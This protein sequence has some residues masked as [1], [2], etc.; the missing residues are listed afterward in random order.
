MTT[1][2]G[3]LFND[4]Q[5]KPL[6]TVGQQQ[7]GAY[8]LFFETGT[9]TPANVYADGALTTPLSQTPGAAQPSCT[10]DS[11]GR[12]NPIYMA[13]A[14]SPYRV[15]LFT[16]GGVKL[17]DTD[18]YVVP[19]SGSVGL[20]LYP[21]T[22][23]ETAASVTIVSYN[24][25]P[26]DVR[27]YGAKCDGATDDTTALT[28][29][30]AQAV[31]TNGASIYFPPATTIGTLTIAS[32]V[33]GL[34]IRGDGMLRSVLTP[35]S[36][37]ANAIAFSNS[38]TVYAVLIEGLGIEAAPGST[39]GNGI[40]FPAA[41][42]QSPFNV[43]VRDCYISGFGQSCILDL[44]GIFTYA[45]SNVLAS[46]SALHCFD[47]LGGNTGTFEGCYGLGPVATTLT[48]TGNLSPGN[49][50]AT[51][52][53]PWAYPTTTQRMVTS[54]GDHVAVTLTNGS[55]AATF[56]AITQQS[57]TISYLLTAAYR[58]HSGQC[59]LRNCNGQNT[60]AAW[61][62]FSDNMAEDGRT[63]Y[64]PVILDGSNVEGFGH[65]GILNKECSM[66]FRGS[67]VLGHAAGAWGVI[68]EPINPYEPGTLDTDVLGTN[69]ATISA[70]FTAAPSGSSG[71]TLN[72]VWGYQTGTWPMTLSTAQVIYA[73]FTF[74]STTVTWSTLVTGSP[75]AT[76]SLPGFVFG[77][78]LHTRLSN[79]SPFTNV[80]SPFGEDLS[81]FNN[82]AGAIWTQST[83][84]LPVAVPGITSQLAKVT[85]SQL[86]AEAAQ[87][88]T[89]ASAVVG[90]YGATP[91][92]QRATTTLQHTSL[93]PST[94]NATVQGAI[95]E[96]MNTL[97][98][99][100]LWGTH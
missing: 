11:S 43:R 77:N 66:T 88:G 97:Y 48:W 91:V 35:P 44:A 82:N 46:G 14:N 65:V 64:C 61:G 69:S 63:A 70:T 21:I 28:A 74:N 59:V 16:A 85:G 57:T 18:P 95:Q 9:L 22:S 58:I 2:T 54:A 55:A 15:Q 41:M 83:E 47:M 8:Y 27:R 76:V 62:I 25:V 96:I 67:D 98:A 51:L 60:G 49:T 30:A 29:A 3:I 71:G 4:P 99:L 26:G 78:W 7:A 1:P 39:A 89:A 52:A 81:F 23:A 36:T 17:E 42:T 92:A 53:T 56:G 34:H 72:A 19:A 86:I 13:S 45:I 50:S 80:L 68:I 12:F 20:I 94:Y 6:S 90:F 33:G 84:R 79:N 40:Y 73:N 31:Q 5:A 100:G 32:S 75:T 93:I 10:A 38:T 37:T 87:I 24:Y